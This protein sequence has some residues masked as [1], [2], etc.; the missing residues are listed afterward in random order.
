MLQELVKSAMEPQ[1]REKLVSFGEEGKTF[2][3]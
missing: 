2:K 1:K 3:T